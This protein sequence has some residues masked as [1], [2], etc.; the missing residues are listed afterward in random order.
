VPGVFDSGFG[1]SSG[2]S[3]SNTKRVLMRVIWGPQGEYVEQLEAMVSN[4][5]AGN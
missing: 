2:T 4:I 5:F 3:D 1:C